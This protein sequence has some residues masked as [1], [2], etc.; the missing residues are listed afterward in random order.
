LNKHNKYK[1]KKK[2]RRDLQNFERESAGVKGE[3]RRRREKRE[4]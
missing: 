1:Y 2:T 4:R 3:I